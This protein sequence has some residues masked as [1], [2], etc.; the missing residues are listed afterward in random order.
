MN[1]IGSIEIEQL[2]HIVNLEK[3]GLQEFIDFLFKEGLIRN[4]YK[5]L[6]I[7]CGADCIEYEKNILKS[8]CK[9]G[10]CG[11]KF[12]IEQIKSI[13]HLVY[14]I[15][16]ED[17]MELDIDE[18]SVNIDKRAEIISIT[19]RQ[20]GIVE[21]KSMDNKQKVIFFGSSKEAENT[22]DEIAALVSKLGCDTLTWNSPNNDIF[23]A[24]DSVLDSL[25]ETARKV[26]GAIFIF[27]DDDETGCRGEIQEI[28]RAHV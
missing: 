15:S 8:N 28:G 17:F 22:M 6:C 13:G 11:K 3:K 24:G 16:Y 14:E 18:I 12:S 2:Q 25:I 19:N 27:N 9:C 10:E 20:E 5:F 23:V 1:E 7:D 4:R 21:E 26:D